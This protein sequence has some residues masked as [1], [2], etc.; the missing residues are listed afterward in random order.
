MNSIEIKLPPLRDHKNDLPELAAYFLEMFCKQNN[1]FIQGFEHTAVHLLTQQDWPGNVRQLR[2]VIERLV[3]LS[4]NT[5]ITADEAQ[6]VLETQNFNKMKNFVS[7]HDAKEA[8]QK[9]FLT[10]SLLTH[11]WNVTETAHS[12][13][14]DRTNLY[15]KMQRLG[16]K[17]IQNIK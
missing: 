3:I 13:K 2:S 16:I 9:E 1:R 17:R 6:L 12:L 5:K 15:K 11:N 10:S 14:I 8:F 4:N 7:Y